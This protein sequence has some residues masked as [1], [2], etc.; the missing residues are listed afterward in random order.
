MDDL[1]WELAIATAEPDGQRNAAVF[2]WLRLLEQQ[3]PAC[4]TRPPPSRYICTILLGFTGLPQFP[5]V[6]RT[7]PKSKGPRGTRSC[8]GSLP[9]IAPDRA[10][11]IPDGGA[12]V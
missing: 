1:K 11:P 3:A 4:D 10:S 5:A 7:T 2:A 9:G 12:V 8:G 6:A